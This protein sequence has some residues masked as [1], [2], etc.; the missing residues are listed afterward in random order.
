MF[1]F[2]PTAKRFA[3]AGAAAAVVLGSAAPAF[4]QEEAETLKSSFSFLN[5]SIQLDAP[6]DSVH[7]LP[8]FRVDRESPVEDPAGV[9]VTFYDSHSLA[10]L[11]EDGSWVDTNNV[12]ATVAAD[13]CLSFNWGARCLLPYDVEAGENYTLNQPVRF[14]AVDEVALDDV[15]AYSATDVGAVD[16]AGFSQVFGY[17]PANDDNLL[18]VAT[19]EVQ[20]TY[21]TDYGL[22]SFD[23]AQ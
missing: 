10:A 23:G 3:A 21:G 2:A 4:A 16:F 5:Q 9:I 12:F 11:Q 8:Q 1:R 18:F 7:V 20:G 19:T 15:G 14:T 6:G 13:N 17:D 22:V